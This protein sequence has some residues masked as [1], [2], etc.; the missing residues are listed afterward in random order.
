MGR[1]ADLLVRGRGEVAAE[2]LG[3][4]CH[5]GGVLEQVGVGSISCSDDPLC[6]VRQPRSERSTR[7]RSVQGANGVPER[8]DK[9]V[10]FGDGSK[11]SIILR[12]CHIPGLAP[13][14][15]TEE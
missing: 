12:V 2:G 13:T 5:A 9:I 11:G 8:L 10:P 1:G 7:H 3:E 15:C 14:N 4:V 6:S